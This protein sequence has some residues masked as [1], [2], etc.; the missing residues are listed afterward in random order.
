MVITS[1]EKEVKAWATKTFRE[2]KKED[3]LP[4]L[5]EFFKKKINLEKLED[6]RD[7][8]VLIYSDEE[9]SFEIGKNMYSSKGYDKNYW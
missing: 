6:D 8:A 7:S 1:A 2:Q 4:A 5:L 3:E 9:R